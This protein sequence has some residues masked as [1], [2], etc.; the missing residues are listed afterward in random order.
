MSKSKTIPPAPRNSG[1]Q[2]GSPFFQPTTSPL[3][4]TNALGPNIGV[5]HPTSREPL[6]PTGL[7]G[8]RGSTSIAYEPPPVQ[9]HHHSLNPDPAISPPRSSTGKPRPASKDPFADLTGGG[10]VSDPFIPRDR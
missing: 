1:T 8:P 3:R 7:N 2:R 9:D 5:S 4:G 6:P 10:L